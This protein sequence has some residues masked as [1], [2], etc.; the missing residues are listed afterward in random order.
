[1]ILAQKYAIIKKAT[2]FT[3]SLGQ[4]LQTHLYYPAST[5]FFGRFSPQQSRRFDYKAPMVTKNKNKTMGSESAVREW[6]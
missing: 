2:I 1:M 3:Q 6:M 5:Y 4:S